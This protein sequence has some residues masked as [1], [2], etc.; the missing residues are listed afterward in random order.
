[1]LRTPRWTNLPVLTT[2]ALPS[3]SVFDLPLVL[4]V[5]F[6]NTHLF[7]DTLERLEPSANRHRTYQPYRLSELERMQNTN[8]AEARV[9]EVQE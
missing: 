4:A 2:P 1:M 8:R 9:H 5:Y 3:I 7:P 6:V